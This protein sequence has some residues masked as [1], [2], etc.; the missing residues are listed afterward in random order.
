MVNL[1][2]VD[3]PISFIK[4]RR[5][6]LHIRVTSARTSR[7]TIN[8]SSPITTKSQ[9]KDN[10]LISKV[11]RRTIRTKGEIGN[12][13]TPTSR[14]R[15]VTGD[16]TRDGITREKPDT[17][18]SRG[19][20]CSIHT[21]LIVVETSAIRVGIGGRDTTTSVGGLARCIDIAVGSGDSTCFTA[22]DTSHGA[23]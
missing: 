21:T 19:P 4:G 16:I 8:I 23:A 17:D 2:R 13:C 9:I 12:K 7:G 22:R 3:F 18:T 20:L 1:E 6:I 15:A 14:I 10:L 5:I 11:R